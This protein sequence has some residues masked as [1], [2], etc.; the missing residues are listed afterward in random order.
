MNAPL[1][2]P[3]TSK[4]L[5]DFV[6][7]TRA[8]TICGERLV[9]AELCSEYLDAEAKARVSEDM[10]QHLDIVEASIASLRERL[11]GTSGSGSLRQ[12]IEVPK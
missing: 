8:A 10:L 12:W 2:L 4:L 6:R 1:P 11:R 5:S 7:A 3:P 9:C